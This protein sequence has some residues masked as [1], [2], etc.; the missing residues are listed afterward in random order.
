MKNYIKKD[1]VDDFFFGLNAEFD[2]VRVQILSKELLTLNET[3]SIIQVEESKR[4]VMLE[5]QN[6]EGLAMVANKGS[7]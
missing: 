1:R 4:S 3:I 2:Q 6:M 5:L 7:D